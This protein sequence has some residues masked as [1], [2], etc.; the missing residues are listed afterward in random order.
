VD[1]IRQ[2]DR[3]TTACSVDWDEARLLANYTSLVE[4]RDDALGGEILN[5]AEQE[6]R[7]VLGNFV[8]LLTGSNVEI[9]FRPADGATMPPSC[10]PPIPQGWVLNAENGMWVKQ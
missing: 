5:R 9:S 10:Q 4:F 3:T 2:Y 1:F 8:E 6:A 7:L